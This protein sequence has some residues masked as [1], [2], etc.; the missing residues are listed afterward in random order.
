MKY[1]AWGAF[2]IAT[3]LLLILA[4]LFVLLVGPAPKGGGIWWDFSIALGFSGTAMLGIMFLLTARFRFPAEPFG[5][6][7]IYYFHK[8]ISVVM[9]IIIILHPSILLM[10]DTGLISLLNP[11]SSPFHISAGLYSVIA[12][13]IVIVSSLYRKPLRIH[14]DGW[15]ILHAFLAVLALLFAVIHIE[16]IGNY[17]KTP[18]KRVLWIILPAAWL[19]I[20]I[21]VRIF[22]PLHLL[23]QSYLVDTVKEERGEAWTLVLRPEDNYT[24]DFRPGQFAWITIRN[25]P[26][27]LREHPFS[28][29]SS[30][31]YKEKLE[32]TIKELGDFSGTIKLLNGGERVYVDGP[33]G[34]FSTERHPSPGYIFIAGGIGIA[35]IMSMLRTLSDRNDKR[36]HKLFYA[37]K[38]LEKL[39]FREDLERLKS[40]LD[41]TIVCILKEAREDWAGER[42]LISRELIGR[43]LPDDYR[44]RDYFVCGPVP[45]I[46][47]VEKA[48]NELHVPFWQVHSELFDLV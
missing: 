16:G 47:I 26:F 20:I 4:P 27:A 18:W 1:L 31:V 37:Y 36:P 13:L 25:S 24:F 19:T 41:L 8:Q 5:I 23:R 7:L 34:A 3:Y 40:S 32:F 6:D 21:Y 10:T 22:R 35:P 44:K 14:Y 46:R 2:W 43:H 28:I 11:L 12:L 45:M 33:Y 9:A 39:T 38:N 17:V 42:G 29:S 48:L 30:A 15:R